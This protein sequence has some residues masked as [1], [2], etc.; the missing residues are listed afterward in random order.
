M[1][2]KVRYSTDGAADDR[3]PRSKSLGEYIAESFGR[4]RKG[5]EVR[6]TI[7]FGNLS[8]VEGA[9]EVHFLI[10]TEFSSERSKHSFVGTPANYFEMEAPPVQQGER[11]K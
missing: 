6:R 10:N 5:E 7:S 9:G 2:D 1:V 11:S 3:Q 4:R 8:P